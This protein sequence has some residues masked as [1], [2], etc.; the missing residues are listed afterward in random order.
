M[1]G[2]AAL[3]HSGPDDATQFSEVDL[4]DSEQVLLRGVTE[5]QYQHHCQELA[6]LQ[7]LYVVEM[8]F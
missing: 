7:A 2:I 3:V 4:G 5:E 8:S 6:R 1:Q